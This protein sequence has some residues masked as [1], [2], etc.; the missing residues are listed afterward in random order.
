MSKPEYKKYLE[1]Q[2]GQLSDAQKMNIS[3]NFDLKK[4]GLEQNFQMQLAQA[5][6]T[7][8]NKWTKHDDGMYTNEAGEIITAD[9]LKNAKLLNNS[10]INKPV[11]AEGGECGF[12]AS[13]GTGMSATPGGNSKEARF[14]AFSETTPKVG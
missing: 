6:Q 10:Y 1:L 5:K 13:R 7:T 2:S 14:K 3:Q 8:N 9:E 11:G 12:Y 4:M